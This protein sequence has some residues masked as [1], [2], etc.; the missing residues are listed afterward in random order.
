[1]TRI[2]RCIESDDD[3]LGESKINI[4]VVTDSKSQVSRWDISKGHPLYERGSYI[5]VPPRSASRDSAKLDASFAVAVLYSTASGNNALNFEP[6]RM[7]LKKHDAGREWMKRVRQDRA[8]A[9]REPFIDPLQSIIKKNSLFSQLPSVA[10]GLK[11]DNDRNRPL[12]TPTLL[13]PDRSTV[14][15]IIAPTD[16]IDSTRKTPD[17]SSYVLATFA[18]IS[19]TLDPSQFRTKNSNIPS[20]PSVTLETEPFGVQTSSGNLKNVDDDPDDDAVNAQSTETSHGVP[21]GMFPRTNSTRRGHYRV[22]R[23]KK[24]RRGRIPFN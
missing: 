5:C 20:K 6:K 11:I 24:R 16:G 13:R 23:L 12:I 17:D 18:V 10:S 9:I 4:L 2:E 14:V 15:T 21:A 19:A 22:Q 1:M 8:C 3:Y 7:M